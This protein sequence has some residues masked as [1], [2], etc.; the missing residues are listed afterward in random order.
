MEKMSPEMLSDEVF[1][2]SPETK[3]GENRLK[4]AAE[5]AAEGRIAWEKKRKLRH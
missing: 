5:I 1:N 3:A 4:S 2:E